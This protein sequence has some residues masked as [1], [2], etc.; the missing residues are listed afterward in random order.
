MTN[1]N[2]IGYVKETFTDALSTISLLN[3]LKN[4]F[5][6]IE[7]FEIDDIDNSNCPVLISEEELWNYSIN[8][9]SRKKIIVLV[10]ECFI[11]NR[12]TKRIGRNLIN[13]TFIDLLIHIFVY[14]INL[15]RNINLINAYSIYDLLL[16]PFMPII[17]IYYGINNY[18]LKNDSDVVSKIKH[19]FHFSRTQYH[20]DKFIKNKEYTDNI[21]LL[22]SHEII[23]D[24]FDLIYNNNKID[25]IILYPKF[26][27][28]FIF[29]I[30]GKELMLISWYGN[31][32]YWRRE[33]IKEIFSSLK[34]IYQNIEIIRSKTTNTS[35]E[36]F[37]MVMR[38]SD[39]WAISSPFKIFDIINCGKVAICEYN[40]H[41]TPMCN[42]SISIK[43]F[44]NLGLNVYD[45]SELI[46][47]LEKIINKKIS[48]YNNHIYNLIEL[49]QNK[50]LELIYRA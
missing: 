23:K 19:E 43:E 17:F 39:L 30:S 12:F 50:L 25:K 5:N 27:Q 47:K 29:E 13:K 33:R 9:K 15:F 28:D 26:Q 37:H 20:F 32:N 48:N 16:L 42:V 38:Q 1:S 2:K 49:N 21:T 8:N 18:I 6:K 31:N 3:V 44:V 22:F 41:D 24:A 46:N 10:L 40:H 7:F 4:S 36:I 14:Y 11:I 35:D 45:H 34:V